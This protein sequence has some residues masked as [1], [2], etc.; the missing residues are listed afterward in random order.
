MDY[1]GLLAERLTEIR[2]NEG[3]TVVDLLIKHI[4]SGTSANKISKTLG[5]HGYP[6]SATT[7]KE[8]RRKAVCK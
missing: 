4:E 5:A 3:T 7:I 6:V 8:Q 2:R 1:S